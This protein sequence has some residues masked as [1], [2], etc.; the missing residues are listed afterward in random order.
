MVNFRPTTS[1]QFS[2]VVDR[3]HFTLLYDG[4]AQRTAECPT[5]EEAIRSI[6]VGQIDRTLWSIQYMDREGG[7]LV[8][9]F[10]R[11]AETVTK[12]ER[13]ELST[14]TRIVA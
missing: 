13:A 11:T 14:T 9:R 12:D 8:Y 3:T 5:L 1:V 6:E 10:P 4:A 2:P 7:T